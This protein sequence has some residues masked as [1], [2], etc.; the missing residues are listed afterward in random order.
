MAKNCKSITKS[1]KKCR[2]LPLKNDVYCYIHSKLTTEQKRVSLRNGG[3]SKVLICSDFPD[4]KL[5]TVS[6]INLFIVMLINKILK[7]E[8]DLRLGTG[9]NYLI[10][11]LMR[12]MELSEFETRLN[13]I[14]KALK[15]NNN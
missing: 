6:E 7:G 9:V 15:N 13:S 2:M 11:T 5:N 4:M 3:K 10:Q 1:G 12:G 14:E 8:M